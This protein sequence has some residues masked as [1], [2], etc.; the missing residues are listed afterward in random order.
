MP[1]KPEFSQIPST[2]QPDVTYV[3]CDWCG[4]MTRLVYVHGHAQCGA[5]H[6]VLIDCCDGRT[7]EAEVES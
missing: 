1:P 5:C 4:Q 6:R 2:R 7:A 3:T